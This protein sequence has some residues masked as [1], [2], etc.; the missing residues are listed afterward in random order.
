MQ[1]LRKILKLV[2]CGKIKTKYSHDTEIGKKDNS[3][4]FITD[5]SGLFE[6][7]VKKKHAP[8]LDEIYNFL[9]ENR[10]VDKHEIKRLYSFDIYDFFAHVGQNGSKCWQVVDVNGHLQEGDV[11]AFVKSGG[12]NRFGHVAIVK[13]EIGRTMDKIVVKVID[14][15]AVD[16]LEDWRQSSAKGIGEGVLELHRSG[17]EIVSVCYETDCEN[18]LARNPASNTP[19]TRKN[20]CVSMS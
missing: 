12:K 13:N 5:C 17:K 15:S 18:C 7:W 1:Y 6:F 8:A 16:H 19:K 2:K 14:S 11:I 20:G 9:Y 4:V 3:F 10:N